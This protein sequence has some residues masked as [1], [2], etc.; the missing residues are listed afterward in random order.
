[1]REILLIILPA[2]YLSAC[3]KKDEYAN[4]NCSQIPTSYSNDIKPIIAANCL[5]A[6]CHGQ[7]S[8]NGYYGTYEGLSIRVKNGTL[9][10]R[11]LYRKDMPKN[12]AALSVDDRRKIKCW[13]D[14]GAANN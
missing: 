13:L 12:A 5:N 7:G 3:Q 1:M 10:E 6:G 2:L 4:I 9:S 11:V 8:S 14:N